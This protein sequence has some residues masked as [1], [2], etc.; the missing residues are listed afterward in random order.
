MLDE[1]KR[2]VQAAESRLS[3]SHH[4][5]PRHESGRPDHALPFYG[6]GTPNLQRMVPP[7]RLPMMLVLV[8]VAAVALSTI[9]Y[10]RRGQIHRRHRLRLVSVVATR[11]P[12]PPP[13]PAPGWVEAPMCQSRPTGV[14]WRP[15]EASG[16]HSKL[17]SS[18]AQPPYGSPPTALGLWWRRSSGVRTS[19][20]RILSRRSG[21]CRATR[22]S[23]RSA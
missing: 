14:A 23:T 4:F 1:L 3:L 5:S 22:S 18:S 2:A 11:C 6:S 10:R 16:R 17:W 9:G 13:R 7:S 19:M 12:E 20:A 15:D 21:A 8:T